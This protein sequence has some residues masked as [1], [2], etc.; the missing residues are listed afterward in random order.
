MMMMMGEKGEEREGKK[1][2][3]ICKRCI[4]LATFSLFLQQLPFAY[5]ICLTF[6]LSQLSIKVD[7]QYKKHQSLLIEKNCSHTFSFLLK[8]FT[9]IKSNI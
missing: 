7:V 9:E 6:S 2:M 8:A 1:Q 5:V 3:S 4:H